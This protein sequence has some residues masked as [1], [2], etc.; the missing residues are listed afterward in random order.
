MARLSTFA[1]T[2]P[3]HLGRLNDLERAA[4]KEEGVCVCVCVC[5]CVFTPSPPESQVRA[6]VLE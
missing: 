6:Y 5:V 2:C 1:A 3:I 4:E